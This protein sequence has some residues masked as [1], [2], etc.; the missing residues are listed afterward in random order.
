MNQK[1]VLL[2]G[3][4]ENDRVIRAIGNYYSKEDADFGKYVVKYLKSMPQSVDLIELYYN[5]IR[6]IKDKNAVG[7]ENWFQLTGQPMLNYFV[8]KTFGKTSLG[9]KL[10]QMLP[11]T[12]KASTGNKVLDD[13]L[14]VAF[15][16]VLNNPK[17]TKNLYTNKSMQK[18]IATVASEI[19]KEIQDDVI[20]YHEKHSKENKNPNENISFGDGKIFIGE[21]IILMEKTGLWDIFKATGKLGWALGKFGAKGLYK[22]G[23][24]LANKAMQDRGYM[25]SS[26]KNMPKGEARGKFQVLDNI[27]KMMPNLNN[28]IQRAI[29]DKLV[30]T[31]FEELEDMIDTVNAKK[32]AELVSAP[33]VSNIIDTSIKLYFK[34]PIFINTIR[35][36]RDLFKNNE[37]VQKLMNE[38]ISQYFRYVITK[39]RDEKRNSEKYFD[40]SYGRNTYKMR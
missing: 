13:Y 33:I 7:F 30:N 23:K 12:T 28:N 21:N 26:A 1:N 35:I 11:F 10:K 31:D 17:V 19:Y 32:M 20:A 29:W 36:V 2:E 3:R 18:D 24:Y 8:N 15:L 14:S 16:K 4:A 38:S 27:M 40:K 6:A 22:G 9:S 25:K 39:L 5:L 37:D 34:K